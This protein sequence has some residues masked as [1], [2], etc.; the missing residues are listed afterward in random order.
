MPSHFWLNDKICNIRQIFQSIKYNRRN[1]RQTRNQALLSIIRFDI[2]LN[3]CA[4][5]MSMNTFA[6]YASDVY[7]LMLFPDERR[8]NRNV[9]EE[10]LHV[11]NRL[12]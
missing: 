4:H 6:V 12:L 11:P 8:K 1:Y 5:A 3:D 10:L 9:I 2:Y 7:S